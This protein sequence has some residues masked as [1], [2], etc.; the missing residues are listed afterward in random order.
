[1][2]HDLAAGDELRDWVGDR[3]WVILW[4]TGESLF[5]VGI[6][7]S[8]FAII[9]FEEIERDPANHKVSDIYEVRR[10]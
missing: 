2:W 4:N 3:H 6:H 8:Y 1:M 7:N 9:P 5:A 10:A